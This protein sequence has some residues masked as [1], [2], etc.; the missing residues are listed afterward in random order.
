VTSTAA[1]W[2]RLAQ[3]VPTVLGVMIISFVLVHVAPGDPVLALAGEYGD[4]SYYDDMRDRFALDRP[5]WEQLPTYFLRLASGDFG[6]SWVQGRPARDVILERVPATLLLTVT[7]LVI[8]TLLGGLLGTIGAVRMGSAA[9]RIINWTTLIVYAS[10][11]FL[12]GQLALLLFVLI[13][14]VAPA[15][16]VTTPG[17]TA[18]GLAALLDVL[19]H[20]ALP[21][22]VLAA[23]QIASVARLTRSTL[24]DELDATYVR[25]A[26]AKGLGPLAVIRHAMRVSLLPIVTLI[27]TRAG[28][29]LGGAVIVES[30][31]G[32]PG[33]GTLL[34]EATANRDAPVVLGIFF[35]VTLA[36]VFAN[37]G[38]D[39]L[40]AR[41]DPRV[42]GNGPTP[43]LRTRH[44]AV[45]RTRPKSSR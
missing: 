4:E 35:G 17:G 1:P 43:R 25:T 34:I 36:V 14:P 44:R 26:R 22:A 38:T 5:L 32:W 11:L 10:P 19:R 29:L 9:D 20:L 27:G 23:P 13:I 12:V 45:D 40:Y 16:G 39:L 7:A 8:S 18:G 30:I 15:F 37:L 2:R 41:I 31:F 6:L 42:R 33:L 28:Q 3:L 21:A 24:Y